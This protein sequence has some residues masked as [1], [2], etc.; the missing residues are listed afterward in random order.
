MD[1]NCALLQGSNIMLGYYNYTVIMTY[2]GLV[3]SLVGI[4]QALN[5]NLLFA[6]ICLMISGVCDMFDGKIASKRDRTDDEKKFGIQ[7][8]SFSDLICFGV[9]PAIICF[10]N[11]RKNKIFMTVSAAYILAALIRLSF[12]NVKEEERQNSTNEQRK[13]YQGLPVTAIALIA[14]LTLLDRGK[15]FP[16]VYAV[17]LLVV[18]ICFLL[19]FTIQKPKLKAKIGMLV[20][21]LAMAIGLLY[22]RHII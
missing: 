18:G 13:S 12:F 5:G 3:V 1:F 2:F 4:F 21:G 22:M 20:I 16:I 7:I 11:D 17:T 10:Q 6:I 9:F 8:D 15:S 19:P 14:P